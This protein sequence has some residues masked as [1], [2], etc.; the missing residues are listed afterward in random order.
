MGHRP[1][2]ARQLDD[3]VFSYWSPLGRPVGRVVAVTYFRRL[4]LAE[5]GPSHGTKT[6]GDDNGAGLPAMDYPHHYAQGDEKVEHGTLLVDR[7]L[8]LTHHA[9]LP[10]SMSELRH[11]SR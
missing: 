7:G 2:Q 6:G 1:V 11:R 10:R 4:I 3:C 9:I 5:V 8:V